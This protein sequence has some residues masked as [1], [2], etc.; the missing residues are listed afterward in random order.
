[1]KK[2]KAKADKQHKFVKLSQSPKSIET[3]KYCQQYFEF[4]YRV[5][6]GPSAYLNLK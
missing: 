2:N 1:M 4:P 6:Y 5:Y 3:V